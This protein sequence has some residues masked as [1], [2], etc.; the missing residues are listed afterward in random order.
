MTP[1]PVGMRCPECASDRTRVRRPQFSGAGGIGASSFSRAPATFTLIAINVVAF[2]AEL[3][4]GGGLMSGNGG[5]T[6]MQN[7]ALCADAVGAGGLCSPPPVISGGGEFWRIITAGFLH[8]NLLHIGFNMFVLYVL[9]VMIEPAI[10]SARTVAIYAVSLVAGS[11]GALLLAD[12]AQNTVGASGAIYGLF[13][14]AMI[15]AWDRGMTQVLS[16]LGFWLVLNLV[17]TFSVSGVS[18]GGHIGGLIG[19]AIAGAIVVAGERRGSARMLG[20]ELAA[21]IALAIAAFAGSIAVANSKQA[22][23]LP[24]G[25]RLAQ[26]ETPA[27]IQARAGTGAER[28]GVGAGPRSGW[29][30]E[31]SSS[32]PSASRGPGREKLAAASTA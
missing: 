28:S 7:G 13:A 19:G 17:F 29:R 1:T 4:T 32:T 31:A 25:V 27:A 15:I 26:A 6:L 8:V 2:I 20:A 18:I 5:G 16:Q 22:P 21:I 23:R 9:G 30:I 11:M 3:A 10:G 12:P 24:P 14:A